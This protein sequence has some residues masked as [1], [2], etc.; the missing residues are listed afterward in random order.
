MCTLTNLFSSL[1]NIVF[2]SVVDVNVENNNFYFFKQLK[3]HNG[4]RL[5]ALQLLNVS[6]NPVTIK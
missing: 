5:V 4:S 2:F 3:F 1:F 6:H